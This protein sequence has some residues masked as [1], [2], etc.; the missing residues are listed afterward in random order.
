MAVTTSN[1]NGYALYNGIKLPDIDSVWTDKVTYPYAAVAL[2]QGQTR[3]L[4]LWSMQASVT[5]TNLVYP[6]GMQIA[7]YDNT[8]SS[9][10][11]SGTDTFPNGSSAAPLTLFSA[12]WCSYDL[13]NTESNSVYVPATDP[14]SLDGMNVIEWDG[15]TTGLTAWGDNH[16]IIGDSVDFNSGVA[17]LDN[18]GTLY[19]TTEMLVEG[20]MSGLVYGDE[21]VVVN[22][23]D[24]GLA[25][26]Y[27]SNGTS[28]A[29][30]TLFAYLSTET[31]P[32]EGGGYDKTAF[33]SGLAMGL[34]GKG[35]PTFTAS[36]T[37]TKGYLVGAALRRK[38]VIVETDVLIDSL[39]I[40]WNSAEVTNNT[41][42][43]FGGVPFVRISNLYALDEEDVQTHGGTLVVNIG[44][45][46]IT[47][48]LVSVTAYD[49]VFLAMY[50]V[51]GEDIY[52]LSVGADNVTFNGTTFPKRGVYV[53]D[54]YVIYGEAECE[55]KSGIEDAHSYNGTI[56]PGL[57]EWDKTAFPYAMIALTSG[58]AT[59]GYIYQLCVCSNPFTMASSDLGDLPYLPNGG[60]YKFCG[61]YSGNVSEDMMNLMQNGYG[62]TPQ[63]ITDGWSEF[64]AAKSQT[65]PATLLMVPIWVNTDLAFPDGTV[66]IEASEPIPL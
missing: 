22:I 45:A 9:W 13:M 32:D 7:L 28:T 56:L 39:P 30:A 61:V 48:P 35:D 3:V 18:V 60:T 57:P 38:R 14:I 58:S 50:N 44:G 37:F 46:T 59:N 63:F 10:T 42:V 25:F 4:A 24:T 11:L 8:G 51:D 55:F 43:T 20:N 33:L 1:G 47:S 26:F 49:T 62:Y 19:V 65:T 54:V 5:D 53:P 31:P 17:V 16:F 34:C 15:D 6:A 27:S 52:A 41:K 21:A 2:I 29:R 36:D 12:E 66:H 23:P 40:Q 64:S